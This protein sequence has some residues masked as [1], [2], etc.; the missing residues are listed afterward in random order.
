MSLGLSRVSQ[1]LEMSSVFCFLGWGSE[2]GGEVVDVE[3]G[4]GSGVGF[5]VESE[6][7][8]GWAVDGVSDSVGGKIF[9]HRP[10]R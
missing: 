4:L 7:V 2:G 1:S 9:L 10:I 6:V 8:V 3:V 5:V